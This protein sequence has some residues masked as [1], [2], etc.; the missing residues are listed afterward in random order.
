MVCEVMGMMESPSSY[1]QNKKKRIEKN[2]LER[3]FMDEEDKTRTMRV[4]TPRQENIFV[5]GNVTNAQ[6]EK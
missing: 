4:V 1:T 3:I 5:K 2:V 6:T